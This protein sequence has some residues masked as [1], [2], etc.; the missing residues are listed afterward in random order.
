MSNPTPASRSRARRFA[1]QALYQMQLSGCSAQEVESQFL[2]D[3]DMKRVDTEYLHELLAGIARYREAIVSTYTP[4]LDRPEAELDPI[5]R[6]V[7]LIGTFE[8]LH[9]I[10]LPFRV[11]INEGVELAKQFGATDSHKFINSILDVLATEHRVAEQASRR[12]Q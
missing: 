8:L 9:R 10:D 2:A 7:L 1:L 3:Y 6:A 12:G 11:V 4:R 5:E